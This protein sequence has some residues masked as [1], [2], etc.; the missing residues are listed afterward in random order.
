MSWFMNTGSDQNKTDA[1]LLSMIQ[2]MRSELESLKG[3][4]S[5]KLQLIHNDILELKDDIRGLKGDLLLTDDVLKSNVN[6]I[7]ALEPARA[8]GGGIGGGKKRR[9]SK[10]RKSKR[11]K[12]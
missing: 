7:S 1:S 9:K 4:E 11:R 5:G 8:E 12:R 6:R 3:I 2:S 10:N